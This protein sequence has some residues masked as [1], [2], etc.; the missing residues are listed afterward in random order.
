MMALRLQS[1][2]APAALVFLLGV[3]E[4]VG[5]LAIGD[6][7]C[8][9]LATVLAFIPSGAVAPG[10]WRRRAAEASL[11]PVG[12]VAVLVAGEVPRQMLLPLLIVAA[13]WASWAAAVRRM[14]WHR[15]ALLTGFF[16]VAARFSVCVV[17]IQSDWVAAAAMLALSF[18]GPWAAAR[19]DRTA[20]LLAG[21]FLAIAPTPESPAVIALAIGLVL[22]VG[23]VQTGRHAEADRFAGWFPLGGAAALVG[24]ALARWGVPDLAFV[25]SDSS[26]VSWVGLALLLLVS[27]CLPPATAGACALLGLLLLGPAGWPVPEGGAVVLDSASPRA[28]LRPGDGGPYML[29]VALAGGERVGTGA[30]VARIFVGGEEVGLRLGAQVPDWSPNSS[31]AQE[32][33]R[34]SADQLV[35]RPS[36]E[37]EAPWKHAGRVWLEVAADDRPVIELNTRIKR[38]ARVMVLIAGPSRPVAPR[39]VAAD[40]WLWWAAALIALIQLIAGTWR[41]SWSWLPWMILAT[42]M[43]ATRMSVEPLFL[44]VQRYGVDLALAAVTVAWIPV[45]VRWMSRGRAFFAAAV[46]LVPIA[47]ATALLTPPMWGDEPY[48][49]ALMESLVTD[50]DL[51][52]VNN[53]ADGGGATSRLV[54][55]TKTLLHSPGLALLL[56]PGFWIF[57]R[58]G[59]LA[60]LG[61]AGAATL[62]LVVTRLQSWIKPQRR[63]VV[64]VGL[65]ACLTYPLATFSSQVWPGVVGGLAVALCLILA[66]RGRV[67]NMIA[68][69]LAFLAAAVKTRLALVTFP[70]VCAGWWRQGRH[71]RVEGI[72]LIV[73]AAVAALIVGWAAMGHPFG[74]FRRLS[75]LMPTDPGLALQAA[76]GLLFD[77][78]GGLAW[79]APLWL[80]A[81][82]AAPA[83]WKVGGP[84][85]RALF[86]GGAVTFVALLGSSEWYGGGS[87]PGRYLVPLLPAVLLALGLLLSKP[88]PRRRLVLVLLPPSAVSWWVLITRPHF[89]IN[90]GDGGWWLTNSLSR[91]FSADARSLFPSFLCPTRATVVVPIALLG[92]AALL[93]WLTRSAGMARILS[94]VA[95]ALWLVAAAGL[96]VTLDARLD[97]VV[98]AEAAQVRHSGGRPVPPR[99]TMGRLSY[100]NGW[101]LAAGNKLRVPLKVRSGDKVRLE[102]WVTPAESAASLVVGWQG[103]ELG[104]VGVRG[105]FESLRVP[106]P[107]PVHGRQWLLIEGQSPPGTTVVI[108]RVVVER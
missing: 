83:M 105:E 36:S 69:V 27:L 98:E 60:L 77:V 7:V 49:L 21:L 47:V 50:V 38:E 88:S 18:V 73:G 89:S 28:R 68:V 86:V 12:L 101:R 19:F 33:G 66:S 81:L 20:G 10:G 53:L 63:V 31:A 99:G 107:A 43:L 57:G 1:W 46:I 42:G 29:D 48:H 8:L 16:G 56:L 76:A 58:E 90:Q 14:E 61:L 96:V 37:P 24:L 23:R 78:A 6:A 26:W 55:E 71:R 45:A 30:T 39:S 4:A 67:G 64:I 41:A 72:L 87:P 59:A 84:G 65:L 51:D 9:S 22:L 95:P 92:I 104:R 17:M 62:G 52:V 54:Q 91:G 32:R 82:A 40:E 35:L 5:R 11:I 70:I 106:D 25:F 102:G 3:L 103:A 100:P 93:L 94:R 79:T 97:G 75:D 85:E 80:L 108:D 34:P 2:A 15:T 44:L 74:I 13:A